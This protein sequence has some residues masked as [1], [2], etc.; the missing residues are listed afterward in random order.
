MLK[1]LVVSHRLQSSWKHTV[2]SLTTLGSLGP[3]LRASGV[4]VHALGWCFGFRGVI[5]AFKLVAL[6]RKLAPDITQ[7]WMYHADF[8]GGIAARLAGRSRVIWGVRTTDLFSGSSRLTAFI[9]WACARLS[10]LIPDAIVFAADASRQRHISFGYSADRMVVIPNGFDL[11]R[12][13][14]TIVERDA[15]RHHCGWAADTLVVGCLARFSHDKDLRN[16]VDA[17]GLV[18]QQFP[19]A[20][21]LMVGRNLDENNAELC[22]WIAKAGAS[23]RFAIL[24]ER[25]DVA[26]C[27]AA[28]D[29][30]AMSSRTEGFPN[31]VGE[32]MAMYLPCVVTDVGDAA[33]LLGNCGVVV[34]KEDSAAL[35]DGI[36]QLLALEAD[37]R[38]AL[39]I[40]AHA[41]I[42]HEFSMARCT[43]RFEALYEE[44][45]RAKGHK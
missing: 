28:M 43:Q 38:R 37:E 7:T 24:G 19:S 22:D 27:L 9:R 21:F 44:V 30:F 18:A 16:F 1:R 45:V 26:I 25:S 36:A 8:A 34:P 2:I 39:G 4:E 29:V 23:E 32:A 31:V 10:E 3:S 15:L 14:A 17:A 11:Q 40:A 33:L 13:Q 42:E 35:A 6:I 20:R 12:L 5:E 41:R